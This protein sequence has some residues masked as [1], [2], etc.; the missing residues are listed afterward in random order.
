MTTAP[1]N[2]HRDALGTVA[3]I[4]AANE[5][6]MQVWRQNEAV[7]AEYLGG[8]GFDLARV[9]AVGFPV[10]HAAADGAVCTTLASHGF[11]LRV[12]L[13]A[14]LIRVNVRGDFVDVFRD[15][16]MFPVRNVHDGSIA[17]FTGRALPWAH[18]S[19]PRW[20]NSR[21]T[22]AFHKGELLYGL[23]EARRTIEQRRRRLAALVVCEGPLDAIAAAVACPVTAVAPAGTA[24]T[25][26][27]AQWIADL[28]T[29]AGLPIVV[30][31]DGDEAG[32]RAAEKSSE[33]IAAS[34]AQAKVTVATLPVG[35]DPASLSA[36]DA[37]TLCA[38]IFGGN[39]GSQA[40]R[41]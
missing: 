18:E 1:V 36:S 11:P 15:R 35:E 34:S 30:A 39:A 10:G 24:M 26:T 29:A 32:Q 38:L 2:D 21:T 28:A 27:Q 31:C 12:A 8:R 25:Q 14:G 6:A 37:Q 33:L 40:L 4:H 41:R 22:R 23:W 7:C 9:V 13:A 3:E 16:L 20:L 17:G 5:L 19:A